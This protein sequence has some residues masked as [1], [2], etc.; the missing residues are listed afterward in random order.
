MVADLS[1]ILSD[2]G[3]CRRK[4]SLRI[5]GDG[6]WPEDLKDAWYPEQDVAAISGKSANSR[7]A[8]LSRRHSVRNRLRYMWVLTYAV[9]TTDRRVVMG[10]VS[11][12]A[13]RLRSKI[14]RG[15]LPDWDPPS[16]TP[17]GTAGTSTSSSQSAKHIR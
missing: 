9:R 3:G 7:A 13:R 12:F 11:D 5:E 6:P 8:A 15:A 14:G 16:F 4:V 17:A 2:R 10:Q 1:E